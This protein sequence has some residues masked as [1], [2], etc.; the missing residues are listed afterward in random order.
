[1]SGRVRDLVRQA[2]L[3][4]SLW[5]RD[6]KGRPARITAILTEQCHLRCDFCRLWEAPHAGVPLDEWREVFRRNPFLRW[7]NLSGGELF[8]RQ[9][10][11]RFLEDVVEAL[12]RLALLDFPTAG[13]RPV[14]AEEAVTALLSTKLPRLVVTVS[15]DGSEAF[16]DRMRGIEGSFARA[17][18]T[19]RRLRRLR[20]RRF[21]VVVGCTLTAEARLQA[22]GLTEALRQRVPGFQEDE[23]HF[24]LAHHSSHYYRNQD[25]TALPEAEALELLEDRA[26]T[27]STLR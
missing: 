3:L 4:G 24:N 20:S 10:L 11:V 21:D 12:P 23:L 17:V 13:Q 27:L 14:E 7:V 22:D 25:F 6:S 15:L 26:P 9:G 1:M 18:E 16:H 8:A 5:Q 2:G 19:L